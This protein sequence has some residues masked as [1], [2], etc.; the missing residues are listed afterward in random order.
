MLVVKLITSTVY[1]PYEPIAYNIFKAPLYTKSY[2]WLVRHVDLWSH[3]LAR[4]GVYPSTHQLHANRYLY[5]D[6]KL[7]GF[8]KS[9][10]F[11]VNKKSWE[12]EELDERLFATVAKK[13]I[14]T[15]R[16]PRG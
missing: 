11:F 8:I 9:L 7:P 4:Q 16:E 12:E 1:E 10:L 15:P 3:F 2:R 14:D 6:R 5:N 13:F